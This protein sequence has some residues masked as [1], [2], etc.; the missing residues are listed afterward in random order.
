[1]PKSK[2]F[3]GSVVGPRA[4]LGIVA[5]L[6]LSACSDPNWAAAP[7]TSA[8]EASAAQP[9]AAVTTPSDVIV[10]NQGRQWR[11]RALGS[12]LSASDRDCLRLV[13]TRADAPAG[14]PVSRSACNA[15]G[16]WT[17]VPGLHADPAGQAI[18]G[19]TITS[20]AQTAG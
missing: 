3:R 11:V 9:S 20:P 1:M 6:T 12:Y 16:I 19:V 2:A 8:A 14:T 4:A 10:D 18:D 13:L 15:G 5:A 7:G 17:I